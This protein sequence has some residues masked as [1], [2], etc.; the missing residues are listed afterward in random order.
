VKSDVASETSGCWVSGLLCLY[1]SVSVCV[2][3]STS[4]WT[5]RRSWWVS[6]GAIVRQ[7][8]T[9]RWT[10]VR[11]L[12]R[13]FYLICFNAYLHDTVGL[14][15]QRVDILKHGAVAINHVHKTA[16]IIPAKSVNRLHYR[17]L[18]LFLINYVVFCIYQT[19]LCRFRDIAIRC[20]KI[21]KFLTLSSA[22]G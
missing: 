4:P 11:H 22:F 1:R 16:Q 18:L 12:Q 7:M 14:H 17:F 9:E 8:E 20:L 3:T 19:V 6:H 15:T 21:S 13:Y 5:I 2:I 10:C